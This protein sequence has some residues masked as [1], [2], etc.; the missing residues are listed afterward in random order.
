MPKY[1][2]C[3]DHFSDLF[4]KAEAL[5]EP[6]FA[7]IKFDRDNGSILLGDERYVLYRGRSMAIALRKQLET[8][9]G[10]SSPTI[11][12]QIGKAC[13]QADAVFM[14]E[15][16]GL[17]SPEMKLAVGPVTFMLEGFARVEVMPESNPVPNDEFL[18]VVSHPNS[19]EAESFMHD[20]IKATSPVDHMNAG[21]SAGWCSEAF[22]LHLD[23]KE[24]S[25]RACGDDMCLFV[26]APTTRLRERIAEIKKIY[27]GE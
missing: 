23:S 21:Y 13:G 5:V 16:L 12:Y 25:C 18:L 24:I 3:P 8:V 6:F 9:L 7:D 22:G 11:I 26:M 1:V 20:K 27:T 4:E 17:S 15:K 10:A 14:A 2:K 19:Y